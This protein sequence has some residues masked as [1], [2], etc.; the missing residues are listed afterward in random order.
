MD[1]QS[2]MQLHILVYKIVSQRIVCGNYLD[3]EGMRS[4]LE[5]QTQK[6]IRRL[7]ELE[8]KTEVESALSLY[9]LYAKKLASRSGALNQA[10]TQVGA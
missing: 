1:L 6:R 3:S 9:D 4:K 5:A 2:R 8:N 10:P 7:A